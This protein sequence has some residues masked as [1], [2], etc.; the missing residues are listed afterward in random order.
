MLRSFQVVYATGAELDGKRDRTP[1]GELVG[2]QPGR[3]PVL[4]ACLQVAPRFRHLERA[5]LEKDVGGPGQG[6]CFWQ[7][8]PDHELHV[9]RRAFELGRDGVC[10]QE[11]RIYVYGAVPSRVL[12]R[13]Q[14]LQLCLTVEAVA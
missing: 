1:L 12:D 11:G 7:H 13:T 10:P 14:G 8:F 4:P 2:V 3:E 5:S 9:L 6:R